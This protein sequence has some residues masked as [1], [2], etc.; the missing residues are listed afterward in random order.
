MSRALAAS[1]VEPHL[2]EIELTE[3]T[4]MHDVDAAAATLRNL[5]AL[6]IRIAIDDFGTGYSSLG[7]LRRFPIDT[8]K[9]DRSFVLDLPADQDSAAIVRAIIHLA[10]SLRLDV[11]AEGVETRLSWNS[12]GR[13]TA[14]VTRVSW[15]V[16]PR[17][18]TPWPRCL[19]ASLA[20]RPG[21]L[22]VGRLRASRRRLPRLRPR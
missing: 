13:K 16:V 7:Y 5:R 2:L 3:T 4:V 6:R 10:R 8:L 12:S 15:V 19:D 11:V 9:I 1:R 14:A 21:P 17:N 20:E 22:P 18:P